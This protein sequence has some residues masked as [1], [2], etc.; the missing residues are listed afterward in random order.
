[1][2]SLS[3]EGL[4]G[5]WMASLPGTSQRGCLARWHEDSK[6]PSQDAPSATDEES[7]ESTFAQALWSK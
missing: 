2:S 1:M 5:L 4:Y 3:M 6:V 7:A